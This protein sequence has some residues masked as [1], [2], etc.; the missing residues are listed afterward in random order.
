MGNIKPLNFLKYFLS[1]AIILSTNT[2]FAFM[3]N[4][5]ENR[6]DKRKQEIEN[7]QKKFEWWPTDATPAPV[8]DD[9]RS[10]YWWMPTTPG[11]M[12]PWGNRGYIYLYKIIYDYKEEELPPPKP[13]ELRA[14]LLVKKIIKN[15]KIYFDYDK[16]DLRPDAIKILESAVSTLK[17][18][19]EADILITGNCDMRGSEA[20]NLKLGNKRGDAVKDFMLEKGVDSDRILIVSKGKLDA[21]AKITDLVGMQQDRNAQFM[22]AEVEEVMIPHGGEAE[23]LGA[24]QIDEN[25][26]LLEEDIDVES[27]IMVS[28]R[29]YT[30]RRGD[31]LKKIAQDQLGASHRWKFLY[32]VNKDRIKDPDLL[33]EGT[34]IIIPIERESQVRTP[35]F[36][37]S[38]EQESDADTYAISDE[39]SFEQESDA[40]TY[41]I[42]KD[43]SLWKIAQKQLGD[44]K[45]WKEIYELNND[46]IKNPDK[47]KVGAT[48]RI[49]R[50]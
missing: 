35:A 36:E 50:K 32:E 28:T 22:I 17:R 2:A 18:N 7:L 48:I 4:F 40:D 3:D 41:T 27:K 30:I 49:P 5:R 6:E 38:V 20:Y 44:G 29:E 9:K 37:E 14:S 43:D 16:V 13:Q 42:S 12:R 1:I 21:V 26:Y 15:I 31:T 39:E 24:V 33:L 46:K 23:K 34:V 19:P 47:L 8:K 11:E 25:K 10:G 45:R